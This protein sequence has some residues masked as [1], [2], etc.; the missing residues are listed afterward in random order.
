MGTGTIYF[1]VVIEISFGAH[2]VPIFTMYITLQYACQ[3]ATESCGAGTR[4]C[5]ISSTLPVS[6]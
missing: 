4:N 1:L 3:R 5:Y 2:H 6:H